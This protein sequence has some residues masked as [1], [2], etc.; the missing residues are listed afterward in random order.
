MLKALLELFLLQPASEKGFIRT[1]LHHW[2]RHPGLKHHFQWHQGVPEVACFSEEVYTTT[3]HDGCCAARGEKNGSQNDGE[4]CQE[5]M[6]EHKHSR[7][8]SQLIGGPPPHPHY[9]C[10]SDCFKSCVTPSAL[11]PAPLVPP[12]KIVHT[13]CV[14]GYFV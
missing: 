10:G 8:G 7:H 14:R 11:I 2:K 3:H 5:Q 1:S 4:L 6:W 13:L 9:C 12:L